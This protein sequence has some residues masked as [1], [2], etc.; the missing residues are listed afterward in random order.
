MKWLGKRCVFMPIRPNIAHRAERKRL[1]PRDSPLTKLVSMRAA[2]LRAVWSATTLEG[3]LDC[4][5]V[6]P[7]IAAPDPGPCN[8]VIPQESMPCRPTAWLS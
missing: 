8:G 5:F 6:I 4:W 3:S 1:T 2:K 7:A